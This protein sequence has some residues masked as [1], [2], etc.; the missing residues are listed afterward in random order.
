MKE[1]DEHNH[2]A[3][4][5]KDPTRVLALTD[6]V[7][8]II[9]TLLVLEL[10]VPTVDPNDKLT[11]VHVISEGAY[12][13]FLFAVSFLLAGVYWVGHR[14]IF[15]LVRKVNNTLVWL[16]IIF[17]MIC[18]LIPFGAALLGTYPHQQFALVAYGL[19]LFMLAGWRLLMYLYVTSHHE[20]THTIVP[21][22]RKKRV[23]GVM[24]FAPVMFLL[25]LSI[26]GIYPTAALVLY[27]ITPPMF[28]TAIT[29]V[30]KSHRGA[31]PIP[32]DQPSGTP[33]ESKKY[34]HF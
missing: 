30:N 29:L 17:L 2:S 19:L 22:K 10:K 26:T 9:M 7:F 33:T 5:L 1:N 14:L 23:V 6:G 11:F 15:S 31:I 8:A 13:L 16:N 28:V 12:K 34:D 21:P 18:S 3:H 4:L 20:L 32:D 24:I 27:A 25:S